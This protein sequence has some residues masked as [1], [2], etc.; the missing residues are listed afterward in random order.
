MNEFYRHTEQG[1][2]RIS[3]PEAEFVNKIKADILFHQQKVKE[4]Q[5]IL[6]DVTLLKEQGEEITY[7]YGANG[8]GYKTIPKPIE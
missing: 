6:V 3:M 5:T 1:T 2:V 7:T 8:Y 4:L